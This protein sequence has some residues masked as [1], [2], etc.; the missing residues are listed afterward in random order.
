MSTCFCLIMCVFV[1][2][3]DIIDNIEANV[4]K[5]VDH[6]AAAKIETKKAVR[7]QTKARKVW[8][9]HTPSHTLIT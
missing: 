3:G 6:V 2:Q 7:Y 8:N 5:S 9:K 4:S 1:F